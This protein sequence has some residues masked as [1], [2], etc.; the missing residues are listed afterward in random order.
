MELARRPAWL[1]ERTAAVEAAARPPGRDLSRP[2]AFFGLP[3]KIAHR[4]LQGISQLCNRSDGR[5]SLSA[6]DPPDV[7][8]MHAGLKAQLLLRQPTVFA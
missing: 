6:L 5:A 3:E 4:N 1:S 8:P 7:V 2:F